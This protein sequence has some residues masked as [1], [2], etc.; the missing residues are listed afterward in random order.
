MQ[1]LK[2]LIDKASEICGGD[3][4]LARK[5]GVSKALLSLMH[6]GQRKITTITAVK[7]ADI[8][9]DDKD[10]ILRA[11]TMMQA[12]GTPD[13]PLIK[14]ILGKELAGGAAG[15]L[16]TSYS[17]DLTSSIPRRTTSLMIEE[18]GLL[19]EV[20]KVNSLY[21]VSSTRGLVRS[22]QRWAGNRLRSQDHLPASG[23]PIPA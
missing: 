13:E 5:L 17:D 16:V 20:T 15:M 10:V 19:K 22:L 3:S 18:R 1:A 21:I 8:T 12:Q 11:A 2:T 4:A 14:E 23:S 6:A 9:G 7:L